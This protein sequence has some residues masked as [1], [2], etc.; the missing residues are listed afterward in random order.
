MGVHRLGRLVEYSCD[1]LRGPSRENALAMMED[2]V[3]DATVGHLLWIRRNG[4]RVA[5]N[6]RRR[7]L[8]SVSEHIAY[9]LSKGCRW[10]VLL[11]VVDER[12]TGEVLSQNRA[13]RTSSRGVGR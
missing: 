12:A 5:G 7:L 2:T 13:G 10:F 6:R 11:V 1:Q 3:D 9:C 8:I 4:I